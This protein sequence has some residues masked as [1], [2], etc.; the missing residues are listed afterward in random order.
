MS[1]KH[2]T[3]LVF[4]ILF[5]LFIAP[6]FSQKPEKIIQPQ[7]LGSIYSHNG[8]PISGDHISIPNRD[9]NEIS[10]SEGNFKI[11]Q[12]DTGS[13]FLKIE[14]IAYKTLFL[15]IVIEADSKI[16]LGKIILL[17]DIFKSDDVLITATILP[18]SIDKI[19]PVTSK[20]SNLDIVRRNSKT[21][22]EALR[23][24][25]GIFIQKTNHGGGSDRKS[26]V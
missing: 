1:K 16:N 2:K 23:E 26:V 20:V 11:S 13:H 25:P 5:A 9:I 24:E 7:I 18:K 21:S 12:I 17:P 4:S 14:H 6:L 8:L 22:A 19:I 10:D 15:T 3:L